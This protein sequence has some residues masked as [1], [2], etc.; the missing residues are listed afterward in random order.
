MSPINLLDG[1]TLPPGQFITM[2]ALGL[3]RDPEFYPNPNKF[4]GMRFYRGTE[5][6]FHSERADHRFA[7]I[8]PHNI[9]WGNGRNTCPGRFYA[10]EV[11]K[12]LLG[13]I[14]LKY[15]ICLPEGQDMRLRNSYLDD[16]IVPNYKQDVMF[17]ERAR[18]QWGRVRGESIEVSY[19]PAGNGRGF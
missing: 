19:I 5:E 8:E 1:T 11:M 10:A 9:F 2:S 12:I 14:I 13:E 7:G 6:Q 18:N 3:S 16:S 17:R 4:D 15:D